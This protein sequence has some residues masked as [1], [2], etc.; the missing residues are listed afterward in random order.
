MCGFS[1]LDEIEPGFTAEMT[2]FCDVNLNAGYFIQPVH[3]DIEVENVT[4]ENENKSI[5]VDPTDDMNVAIVLELPTLVV[6]RW[7]FIF[8]SMLAFFLLA[9][10]FIFILRSGSINLRMDD[11]ALLQFFLTFFL[12]V[13]CSPVCSSSSLRDLHNNAKFKLD[14]TALTL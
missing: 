14:D 7:R 9:R 5:A 2:I 4:Q 1:P 13:E 10:F 12:E 11:D 6:A 3:D 8:P